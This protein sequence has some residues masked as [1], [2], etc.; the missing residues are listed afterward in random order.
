MTLDL[1]CS[2]NLWSIQYNTSI[3]PGLIFKFNMEIWEHVQW[4]YHYLLGLHMIVFVTRGNFVIE[5]CALNSRALCRAHA[6]CTESGILNL[7]QGCSYGVTIAMPLCHRHSGDPSKSNSA[8]R[9]QEPSPKVVRYRLAYSLAL[10][11]G[12]TYGEWRHN[13]RGYVSIVVTSIDRTPLDADCMKS[14]LHTLVLLNKGTRCYEVIFFL[15]LVRAFF[16]SIRF[17]FTV[18]W[19]PIWQLGNLAGCS[20]GS[21]LM[22]LGTFVSRGLK[23]LGNILVW[24]HIFLWLIWGTIGHSWGWVTV[25]LTIKVS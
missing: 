18:F 8:S 19:Q 21:K 13:Y 22:I 16:D 4:A 25:S 3:G 7:F 12:W 23:L 14:L 17:L 20:W 5:N 10:L 24:A 2:A 15:E 1:P 6:F 9:L 11:S